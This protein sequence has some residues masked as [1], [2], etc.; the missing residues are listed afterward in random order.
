MRP[1]FSGD[2]AKTDDVVVELQ[3]SVD[4]ATGSRIVAAELT[5]QRR[6]RLQRRPRTP[7]ERLWPAAPLEGS[8]GVAADWPGAKT[9]DGK[10]H[11]AVVDGARSDDV[12]FGCRTRRSE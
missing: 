3:I 11:R 2:G 4:D 1:N 7:V 12:D 6:L 9:T 5:L 8:N 10:F